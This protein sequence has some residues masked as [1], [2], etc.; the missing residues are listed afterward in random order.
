MAPFSGTA[1]VPTP[2]HTSSC[3]HASFME[4]GLKN[5]LFMIYAYTYSF[6][7]KSPVEVLEK[8]NTYLKSNVILSWIHILVDNSSWQLNLIY[9]RQIYM[10][11]CI[12]LLIV[13][14]IVGRGCVKLAHPKWFLQNTTTSI[15]PKK[16]VLIYFKLLHQQTFNLKE[17]CVINSLLVLDIEIIIS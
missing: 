5:H 2:S 15:I 12:W 4:V 14:P 6:E 17:K 16:L 7:T 13:I 1:V 8:K 11:I 3:V 9:L 10:D